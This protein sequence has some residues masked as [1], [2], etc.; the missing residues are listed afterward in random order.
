MDNVT[1]GMQYK[2]A[3]SIKNKKNEICSKC[4]KKFQGRFNQ[5]I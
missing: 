3:V 5:Q 1:R 4:I 2:E